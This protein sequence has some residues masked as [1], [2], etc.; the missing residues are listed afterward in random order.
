MSLFDTTPNMPGEKTS[1]NPT[2]YLAIDIEN[3]VFAPNDV[4]V[5]NDLLVYGNLQ[6]QDQVSIYDKVYIENNN[7]VNIK[8]QNVNIM[9]SAMNLATATLDVEATGSVTFRGKSV[10]ATMDDLTLIMNKPASLT[11]NDS[12]AFHGKND[13]NVTIDP[14]KSLHISGDVGITGQFKVDG[15]IEVNNGDIVLNGCSVGELV[16]S[17]FKPVHYQT[18]NAN[19]ACQSIYG[20]D[21]PAA[22]IPP[23]LNLHVA[24]TQGWYYADSTLTDYNSNFPLEND[25]KNKMNWYFAPGVINGDFPSTI[26]NFKGFNIGTTLYNT[27]VPYVVI[28][29]QPKTGENNGTATSKWYQSK[30][31]FICSSLTEEQKTIAKKVDRNG[32]STGGLQASLTYGDYSNT[33]TMG[34]Q[35]L[36]LTYDPTYSV[37]NTKD[38]AYPLASNLSITEVLS[39]IADQQ[40]MWYTIQTGSGESNYSFT[41]HDYTFMESHMSHTTPDRAIEVAFVNVLP[42]IMG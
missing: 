24:F 39:L 41:V 6:V 20:G 15:S 23:E 42:S 14:T 13:V 27:N 17:T 18:R 28:Y 29:T 21:V 30:I 32:I 26:G 11:A 19:F 7:A 1:I 33:Q 12:V 2:R 5:H 35:N 25:K 40:I 4:T 9:S 3:N 37:I 16:S 31:N 22:A 36:S 34:L 38:V 10:N 8:T